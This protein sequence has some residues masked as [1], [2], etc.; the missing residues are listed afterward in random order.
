MMT[1]EPGMIAYLKEPYKGHRAVQLIKKYHY[2]WLVELVGSGL[3]IEIYDDEL[4]FVDD[5]D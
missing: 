5:F 1:L 2:R 3:Q 4:D